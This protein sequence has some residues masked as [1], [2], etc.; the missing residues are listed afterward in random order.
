MLDT[1]RLLARAFFVRLFESELMPPGLPQV[2]LVI[3]SLSMMAAPGFI[4]AFEVQRRYTYL[5]R[6][7]PAR[8]RDAILSDQLLF[9]TYSMLAVGL[10]ALDIWEGVFPDRRDARTL[11]VLPLRTRTHVVA[12]LGALAAVAAL[13]SAG[14]NIM[15]AIVYGNVLW[16]Y[17]AAAGA[18]RAM[19]GHLIATGLAGLCVFFTLVTAQGVLLNA[20]GRHTAQRL[21]IAL[22]GLFVVVLLQAL[23]FVPSLAGLM[24]AA[25]RGE[26]DTVAAFLPPAW[27][28]ALF[29][30][31]AGTPA[32]G[33]G[34]F[35]AA[36][37]AA[38]LASM[39]LAAVLL[40][41]SYPRLMRMALET[42]DRR[43]ASRDGILWRVWAG[44]RWGATRHPVRSAVARFTLR[45]VM[46]SR[47]H[48]ILLAMYAGVGTA[49][50]VST[51]VPF[52]VARG[53][54]AIW[55][56]HVV[57]LSAPLIVNFW[58]LCGL[59][60]LFAV[61]AE[62]RANWALRL[63]APDDQI[64][65]AVRGVRV[66]MLQLVAGPVA[67]AAGAAG[68]VLWGP[69]AA[70]V[71]VVFTAAAGLLLVD[72]LLVRLRKIP[73]TCTYH[74]GRSRA[75][76]LWPLYVAAF[77]AYAFGLARLE[78]IAMS[79]WLALLATVLA[80]GALDR[81]LAL[82]RRHDLQTPPG[83]TYAE[84]DPDALF[85]GFRLSEGIA[86]RTRPPARATA[87]Q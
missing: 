9:V 11:G 64:L 3:G 71:H 22:Q 56:P 32:G 35:A 41:W 5:W 81:G 52:L 28:V 42:P 50:V 75:R 44:R 7:D 45:T 21:A 29:S 20:F 15:S 78:A 85:A 18:L 23:M 30:V 65:E 39:A 63:Y 2:Q 31:L 25:F 49:L 79:N 24:R 38:T 16:A 53:A 40:A 86:A 87:P 54:A 14:A 1:E 60:V 43:A 59:R 51:L 74:P 66:A 6:T 68:L 48:L 61:P 62:I 82:L 58:V 33:A 8:L 77:G 10:V 34:G 13:F 47:T 4:V 36:A 73:F 26:P 67:I 76:F 46:R 69:R 84:E 17:G 72:L 12:R 80:I 37:V 57:L 70:A 27:F 55:A 19:S 83:I